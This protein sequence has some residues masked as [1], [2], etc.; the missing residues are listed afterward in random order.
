MW[1]T[2]SNY[3]MLVHW[4]FLILML[5]LLTALPQPENVFKIQDHEILTLSGKI[6]FIEKTRE[7]LILAELVALVGS[8]QSPVL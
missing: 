5:Y 4:S 6:I 2:T 3:F 1:V 7:D 8:R